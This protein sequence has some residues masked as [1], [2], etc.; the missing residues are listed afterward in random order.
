MYHIGYEV[1]EWTDTADT[2]PLSVLSPQRLPPGLQGSRIT[3]DRF[4]VSGFTDY[5]S[6]WLRSTVS[7]FTFRL[8]FLP[9]LSNVINNNYNSNKEEFPITPQIC[10][11]R[12]ILSQ[13]RESR[14]CCQ[15]AYWI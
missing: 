15:T 2:P 5:I 14:Q 12:V 6:S 9:F 3:T 10:T 1:P 7:S 8:E 13:S 11:I 4:P